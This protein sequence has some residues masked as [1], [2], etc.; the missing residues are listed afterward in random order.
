MDALEPRSFENSRLCFAS[1]MLI[2]N[3][4]STLS[5][6]RDLGIIET[7]LHM[8]YCVTLAKMPNLVLSCC[9]ANELTDDFI[10]IPRKEIDFCQNV[11]N[12]SGSIF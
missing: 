5:A 8:L 12:E 3:A 7:Y 2:C 6:E 10:M 9:H 4:T 11:K 1:L